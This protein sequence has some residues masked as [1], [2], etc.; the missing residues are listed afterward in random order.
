VAACVAPWLAPVRAE[1]NLILAAS[2][3]ANTHVTLRV[4][5]P[6][7][8][9]VNAQGAGILK[10]DPRYG[11]PL[12]TASN[13]YDRVLNDVV[14]IVFGSLNVISGK[15]VRTLV[16]QLPFLSESAEDGSVAFWRLYKSGLLDSEFDETIPLSLC[17]YPQ[18]G[19]HLAKA[20]T[21]IDRLDGL[22]LA[23]NSKVLGD[24]AARL[25]ANPISLPTPDVY[26]AVQRG[27]VNGM[28][29]Q[30]TTFEPYKFAEVTTYHV[31]A[32][33]GV[34]T[35]GV[36][37]ARK[38][39]A[40]LPADVRRII[41]A[42]AGEKFSRQ[43]GAF[44]DQVSKEA[45]QS[46]AALPGHQIVGLSPAQTEA[47]RRATASIAEEWVKETPD[48]ATVLLEYRKIYAGVKSGS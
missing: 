36:L 10:I 20:P 8:G 27:V 25:G 16:V 34:G 19:V 13:F 48:G 39:Y 26:L 23:V 18:Q 33:L 24:I 14:Q 42:N 3:P 37:M 38:K 45:R 41:D 15:F 12:V 40:A 46:V 7:V 17:V 29:A 9:S 32:Q 44:W 2:V 1:E 21:S 47:W 4:F 43:F 5:A 28:L 30:W 6:W 35:S 11:P 22:Q 31:E